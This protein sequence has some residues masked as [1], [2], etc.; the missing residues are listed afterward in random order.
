MNVH[1]EYEFNDRS[2]H[3]HQCRRP[4]PADMTFTINIVLYSWRTSGSLRV[5]E[6]RTPSACLHVWMSRLTTILSVIWLTWRTTIL[7]GLQVFRESKRLLRQ[8][9]RHDPH[10]VRARF[11]RDAGG[12]EVVGAVPSTTLAGH[13]RP[14]RQRRHPRCG[15]SPSGYP[16]PV[17]LMVAVL[18]RIVESTVLRINLSE[19]L[20][21]SQEVL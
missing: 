7:C 10:V 20:C 11:L 6:H 16:F 15:K 21:Q 1:D 19:Q 18:V 8:T 17:V 9:W 12:Q 13:S 5:H 2:P 4:C 14:L 3:W